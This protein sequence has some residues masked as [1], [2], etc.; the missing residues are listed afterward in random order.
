MTTTAADDGTVAAGE[1][2]APRPV[3][4]FFSVW[5]DAWWLTVV[6]G[7]SCGLVCGGFISVAFFFWT[8]PVGLYLGA[9]LG[10][11]L[12]LVIAIALTRAAPPSEPGVLARSVQWV[13]I[14]IA[15]TVIGTI[16]VYATGALAFF[17]DDVDFRVLGVAALACNG[18]LA[19]A[20]AAAI[21]RECGYR[22]ATRHLHR[23][24][25]TTPRR[26]PIYEWLRRR[27]AANKGTR[28]SGSAS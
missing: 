8:I 26:L 24:G 16:N 9:V 28:S 20:A 17:A 18:A 7:G 21:G 4:T 12:G 5:A 2:E 13:G 19:V 3:R 6:G 22:L 14:S 23:F 1:R 15:V 10:L 27:P 25:H 11:P